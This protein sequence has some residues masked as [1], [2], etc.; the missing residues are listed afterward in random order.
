MRRLL[1]LRPEPGLSHSAARA[2]GLGL[3]VI[4]CP[5]FR[6]EPLAWAVP[7]AGYDALL[8]TSANAVRHGGPGLESLR[9]LPVHAVGQATADA[10]REAG[11]R[12][13][14]VGEQGVEALLGEIAATAR[15][16]H[17]AGEDQ[18]VAPA[19]VQIERRI[20]YRSSPIDRP[21]LPPLSGLVVAVHSPRAGR[22][23]A[24]LAEDRTTTMIA[25]ISPAAAAACGVGWERVEAAATPDDPTL[26]AL[27][28]RLCQDSAQR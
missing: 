8:L 3:K 1:L 20:V 2:G 7:D 13:L 17:L 21:A 23:L 22:R 18:L 15:L 5:L 16:L 28:A 24:E 6:V 19:T 27:A 10:A 4:A 26:L 11:F 14:T 9:S 25:A 12:V